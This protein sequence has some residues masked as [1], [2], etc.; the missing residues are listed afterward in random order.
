MRAGAARGTE[1]RRRGADGGASEDM[2]PVT[3]KVGGENMCMHNVK[4]HDRGTCKFISQTLC[5]GALFPKEFKLEEEYQR[6][7]KWCFSPKRKCA[8]VGSSEILMNAS[9]GGKIDS[10]EAVIRMNDAP[11]GRDIPKLKDHVGTKTTMRFM[12]HHAQALESERSL[13]VCQFLQEPDTPCGML[14]SASPKQCDATCQIPRSQSCRSLQKGWIR[15]SSEPDW[16]RNL[17]IMDHMHPGI[18]QKIWNQPTVGMKALAYAMHTCD[19]IELFGFG[20]SCSGKI[21]ARY[22]DQRGIRLEESRYTDEFDWLTLAANPSAGLVS[23]RLPAE[24]RGWATVKRIKMF[25][26]A[27]LKERSKLA[28]TRNHQF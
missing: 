16:G 21:G 12:N 26:P 22:Y 5:S 27:C 17:V 9:W 3:Y 15:N 4:R 7:L 14:C 2:K 23:E 8:L 18:A 19:S 24:L 13:E 10:F 28:F 6:S 25:V 1:G 20:D 11:T